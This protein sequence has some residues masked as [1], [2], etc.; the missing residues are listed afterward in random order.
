M[1]LK[2]F[3]SSQKRRAIQAPQ[4]HLT[5]QDIDANAAIAAA[6]RDE[7]IRRAEEARWEAWVNA[8]KKR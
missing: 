5:Q 4:P 1:G 3:T 2:F 7:E 8:Q 6:R